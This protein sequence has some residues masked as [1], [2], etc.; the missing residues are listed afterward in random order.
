MFE[1]CDLIHRYTRA[2][3]IAD[4]V[5]VDVTATAR[6]AGIRFPVAL[7]RGVWERCVSV[8]AGVVCQD[9]GGRLWDVV[10]LLACAIR[11]TKGNGRE[12]RFG[13]HVRNDNRDG[14]PPLIRLKAICGPGDHGEPV[15]TVMLPDED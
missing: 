7:T 13:V 10:W 3:A 11:G 8:P 14:V 2:E 4:G 9:E 5:L 12:V 6:E 1:D 15:I